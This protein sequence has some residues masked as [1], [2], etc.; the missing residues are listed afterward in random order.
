ME[1]IKYYR[2]DKCKYSSIK[3]TSF[4]IFGHDDYDCYC[5]ESGDKKEVSYFYCVNKCKKGINV[6]K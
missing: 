3:Y 6:K 1:E 2:F 5:S 4:D